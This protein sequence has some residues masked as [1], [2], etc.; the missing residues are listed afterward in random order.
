MALGLRGAAMK[1]PP[2]F[3]A[4]DL[5]GTVLVESVGLTRRT[6]AAFK[7]LKAG[8]L[9]PLVATGRPRK[10][11][12]RWV[13]ALGADSGLVCHNGALVYDSTARILTETT[14]PEATARRL[15]EE[16]RH[17]DVH[18]HGFAGDDWLYETIRPGTLRY[19][20]RAAFPGLKVSFDDMPR[21]GFHKAMFVGTEEEAPLVAGRIRESLGE[22]LEVFPTGSGF[23]ELVAPGIGKGKSLARLVETLG[24]TMDEVIAFGDAWNDED[25]L[26]MAGIG[27]AMG[28]APEE[29]KT[30]IG[31]TTTTV[32]EDGVAVW[33][34][35]HFGLPAWRY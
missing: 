15:V 18:F 3:I 29:L 16:A 25:M 26:L 24:G 1:R 8:G 23:V 6:L 14:I 17:I 21:L 12:I 28:N 7:S 30:R 27:V 5:D 22:L 34:E 4:V 19:E 11:A 33:L 13:E 35:E 10:S 9:I 32:A 31:R 20:G 2:R